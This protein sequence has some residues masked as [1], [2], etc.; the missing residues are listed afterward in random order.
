M[1]K[2]SWIIIGISGGVC[3]LIII[4]LLGPGLMRDWETYKVT[5]TAQKELSELSQKKTVLSELS[6]NTELEK[7][8]TTAAAYIPEEAKSSELVLELSAIVAE[9]QMSVEQIS[10]EAAAAPAKEEDV[11]TDNTKGATAS[12][13]TKTTAPTAAQPV[14]FTLKISGTF[15]SLMYFSK[16][17]ETSNRLITIQGLNLTQEEEKFTAEIKGVAYWKKVGTVD[18]NLTNITVA[19]ETLQ[20]FANLRQYST[21]IDTTTDAGYGRANPFQ[22]VN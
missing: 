17:M 6:K 19:T 15:E 20:K 7:I 22:T 8:T 1:N 2:T 10:L 18:N 12:Q 21:P 16:L 5:K 9:A 14:G 11:V 3:L 4:F 13:T